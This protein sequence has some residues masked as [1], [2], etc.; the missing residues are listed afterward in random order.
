MDGISRKLVELDDDI[1]IACIIDDGHAIDYFVRSGVPVPDEWRS[2]N[3][4]VQTA[5]IMSMVMQ[6]QDYLG[7]LKFIHFH[8]ERVDVLH[9][10]LSE[11]KILVVVIQPQTLDGRLVSM[12]HDHVKTLVTT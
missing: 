2:S 11:K 10:A 5:L 1:L 8:M 7:R 12:I 9:F 4:S 6:S 3:L